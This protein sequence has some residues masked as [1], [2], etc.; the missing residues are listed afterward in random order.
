MVDHVMQQR[1]ERTVEIIQSEQ[2]QEK[3]SILK[4]GTV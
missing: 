1:E 3:K 4:M 2:Q